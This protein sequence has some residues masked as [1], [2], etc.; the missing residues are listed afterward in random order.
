MKIISRHRNPLGLKDRDDHHLHSDAA[1]RLHLMCWSSQNSTE[2]RRALHQRDRTRKRAVEPEPA[3]K[4]LDIIFN[5]LPSVNL[6]VQ[7]NACMCLKTC[8]KKPLSIVVIIRGV[9]FHWDVLDEAQK[10]H[11]DGFIFVKN[12][13][14]RCPVITACCFLLTSLETRCGAHPSSFCTSAIQ[15]IF[16]VP[17]ICIIMRIISENDDRTTWFA[18]VRPS[19]VSAM[20]KTQIVSMAPEAL[21]HR[22]ISWQPQAL[23]MVHPALRTHV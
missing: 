17:S 18:C 2:A 4:K 15:T 22:R 19:T 5:L 21:N 9:C 8:S 14:I 6:L 1:D 7:S 3:P 20:R 10:I 16:K 23:Q 13:K 11:E 12:R